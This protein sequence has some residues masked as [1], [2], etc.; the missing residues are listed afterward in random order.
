MSDGPHG[1]MIARWL[2]S[3]GLDLLML[4]TS[5]RARASTSRRGPERWKTSF[6]APLF[7]RTSPQRLAARPVGAPENGFPYMTRSRRIV[8]EADLTSLCQPT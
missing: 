2:Y 3:R 5:C 8:A 1:H 7:E 4:P 6:S